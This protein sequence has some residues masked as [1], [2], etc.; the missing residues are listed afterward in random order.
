MERPGA[1]FLFQIDHLSGEEVGY[2][3]EQLYGWGPGM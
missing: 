3:V 2:L 1:L